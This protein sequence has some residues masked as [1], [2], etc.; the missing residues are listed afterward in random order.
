MKKNLKY[1]GKILLS[2]TLNIVIILNM[3]FGINIYQVS[4]HNHTFTEDIAI[5]SSESEKDL[6]DL[7]VMNDD[8]EEEASSHSHSL[9]DED[10]EVRAAVEKAQSFAGLTVIAEASDG[11]KFYC[12]LEGHWVDGSSY[13]DQSENMSMGTIPHCT[14]C[15]QDEHCLACHDIAYTCSDCDV[16]FECLEDVFSQSE[17]EHY[18]VDCGDCFSNVEICERSTDDAPHCVDE[19]SG[20]HCPLCDAYGDDV[21]PDCGVCDD[22]VANEGA[23]HYCEFCGECM[24]AGGTHCEGD[25]SSTHCSVCCDDG[26]YHCGECGEFD[27]DPPCEDCGF[28]DSCAEGMTDSGEHYCEISGACMVDQTEC[29]YGYPHLADECQ[30]CTTCGDNL[31]ATG[32]ISEDYTAEAG[33]NTCIDC[34]IDYGADAGCTMGL[35]MYSSD[36]D[37]HMCEQ[38]GNDPCTVGDG[39]VCEECGLCSDCCEEN[40]RDAGYGDAADDDVCMRSPDIFTYSSYLLAH[41]T[42]CSSNHA[43]LTWVALPNGTHHV[44]DCPDCDDDLSFMTALHKSSGTWETTVEATPGNLGTKVQKCTDCGAITASKSYEH[45]DHTH[46]Y[47]FKYDAD[48]HWQECT[49]CNEMSDSG[50]SN[51]AFD[52]DAYNAICT[53]CGMQRANLILDSIDTITIPA[54]LNLEQIKAGNYHIVDLVAHTKERNV[55]YYWEVITSL[56]DG[57]G[58]DPSLLYDENG[59]QDDNGY[60]VKQAKTTITL[61]DDYITHYLMTD[62][63]TSCESAIYVICYLKDPSREKAASADIEGDYITVAHGN[64]LKYELHPTDKT[65]HNITCLDCNTLIGTEKHDYGSDN[66]YDTCIDCGTVGLPKITLQPENINR[67][68]NGNPQYTFKVAAEGAGLEYTWYWRNASVENSEFKPVTTDW[69]D[70]YGQ[71]M[72]LTYEA[73][74]N[75]CA[76]DYDKLE[77]YCVV[78]NYAGKV[79][80]R[81]VKLNVQ[82]K[83]VTKYNTFDHWIECEYCDLEKSKQRHDTYTMFANA[84]DDYVGLWD[85]SVDGSLASVNLQGSDAQSWIDNIDYSKAKSVPMGSLGTVTQIVKCYDCNHK[86]ENTNYEQKTLPPSPCSSFN[87]FGRH[88][89]TLYHN[90]YG[91]WNGCS[92]CD[93]VAPDS[94]TLHTLEFASPAPSYNAEGKGYETWDCTSCHY[95]ELREVTKQRE[96][97]TYTINHLNSDLKDSA[98]VVSGSEDEFTYNL[99]QLSEGYKP[100]SVTLS[101]YTPTYTVLGTANYGTVSGDITFASNGTGGYTI[102]FDR[103]AADHWTD[104]T[105]TVNYTKLVNVTI[106]N[107]SGSG[108]YELGSTFPIVADTIDGATFKEWVYVSSYSGFADGIDFVGDTQADRNAQRVEASTSLKLTDE[109]F[110]GTLYNITIRATYTAVET[111]TKTVGYDHDNNPATALLEV[112]NHLPG[113]MVTVKNV[114]AADSDTAYE[115]FSHW[116]LTWEGETTPADTFTPGE[117]FNMQNKNAVLSPVY[118]MGEVPTGSIVFSQ[119]A[120]PSASNIPLSIT[121]DVG[122]V[123]A[124]PASTPYCDGYEFEEWQ[125]TTNITYAPGENIAVKSGVTRVVAQ[126]S[127]AASDT[128]NNLISVHQPN[129][130]VGTA[131]SPT[132]TYKGGATEPNGGAVT[133]WYKVQS[134]FDHTY[135]TTAPT[136]AGNYTVSARSNANGTVPSKTVTANFTILSAGVTPQNL[137]FAETTVYKTYGDDNFINTIS[138]NLTT[139]IY[140]STNDSVAQVN[141]NTGEVTIVGVGSVEITVTAI[142][143]F[144]ISSASSSYTINVAKKDLLI[145]ANNITKTVNSVAPLITDLSYT[146]DGL[147][148]GDNLYTEPTIGFASAVDMSKTGTVDIIVSGAVASDNYNIIYVKGILTINPRA[149]SG[150]G[151]TDYFDVEIEV[152]GRGKVSPNGGMDKTE[153]LLEGENIILTFTADEGHEVKDV[154]VNGKSVGEMD[155]YT[156]NGIGKDYLIRVVFGEEG[157]NVVGPPVDLTPP[158]ITAT[159]QTTTTTPTGG[160]ST[161]TSDSESTTTEVDTSPEPEKVAEAD[162][163]PPKEEEKEGET[164]GEI[165]VSTDNNTSTET[166]SSNMGLYLTLGAITVAAAGGAFTYRKRMAKPKE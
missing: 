72:S 18:C 65:L 133:F 140:D 38:C 123:Y 54:G 84:T 49:I 32:N 162:G 145:M 66:Q 25:Q 119:G 33:E 136:T 15:C 87:N 8:S 115:V 39:T 156:I 7:V 92:Y 42:T 130:T 149:S 134:A 41:P 127:D 161:N 128:E 78:S 24:V 36:W 21:C 114:K 132:V 90:E 154:I 95:S 53:I 107:G 142:S 1:H 120:V 150:G 19:C 3:V 166:S 144:N 99:P 138:G 158:V 37:D 74:P 124:I 121:D 35:E 104:T 9:N 50:K 151:I 4:Q 58:V 60:Y 131:V 63:V 10:P 159:T 69:D 97:A 30:C 34:A 61:P 83:E 109:A 85:V 44:A 147:L 122:S 17:D 31:F 111:E 98:V 155:K 117:T 11:D 116:A 164:S 141:R 26:A 82:H 5:S 43:N 40:T 100:T 52:S 28:C 67:V 73:D 163:S 47:V 48:K 20:L 59:V 94:L 153:T 14:D 56:N 80:S 126:W 75:A 6:P 89:G 57:L 165:D 51:H 108:S 70:P 55:L 125:T 152:D 2:Y 112:T 93:Y 110:E 86:I 148:E 157:T 64:N 146:T 113:D 139:L 143:T 23:E 135:T 106:Q 71:E 101:A 16:C 137:S 88:A 91:H 77:F 45:V 13:C 68:N 22:C 118:V 76:D 103:A 102:T 27:G 29:E 129:V 46:D 81:T 12:E 160:T 62:G 96:D 79:Q 105:V